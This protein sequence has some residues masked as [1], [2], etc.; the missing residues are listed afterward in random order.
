MTSGARLPSGQN[1]FSQAGKAGTGTVQSDTTDVNGNIL[2][3]VWVGTPVD[4]IKK[5]LKYNPKASSVKIDSKTFEIKKF[6]EKGRKE[7]PRFVF[8]G[9]YGRPRKVKPGEVDPHEEKRSNQ[10]WRLEDHED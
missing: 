9:K 1:L 10:Q 4:I 8:T 7:T 2:K 3:Q 5:V 6:A